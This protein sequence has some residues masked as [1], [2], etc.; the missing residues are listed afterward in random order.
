MISKWWSSAR[1]GGWLAS[2][3]RQSDLRLWDVGTRRQAASWPDQAGPA[4]VPGG[5]SL[6]TARHRQ[7]LRWPVRSLGPGGADGIGIGPA[8]TVPGPV[9]PHV[10]EPVAP[11]EEGI[12]AW[13]WR[14]PRDL[15][16]TNFDRSVVGLY[17][18]AEVTREKW[19]AKMNRA[20][21][22]A[23]SPDGHWVAAGSFEGG[24]GVQIREADSGRLEKELLT[25]DA[26]VAFSPNSRWLYTATGRLAPRGP[27][28]RAW[29]VGTWEAAHGLALDRS[30]SAPTGLAASPDGRALAV[31]ISQDAVRLLDAASFAEI[32]TLSAPE[33]GLIGSIRFSPDSAMLAFWASHLVHLWDL[34]RL[35]KEL[36]EVGLDWDALPYPDAPE[37]APRPRRVEVDLGGP[38]SASV[39][40]SP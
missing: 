6:L 13:C 15:F 3:Q 2:A 10:P 12:A 22:A 34:R 9:P 25:A 21:F 40:S 17:E 28:V 32:G 19:T 39:Q 14:G 11:S 27:E 24:N 38:G 7:L 23:A 5:E 16:V 37:V 31:S 35:R 4:W 29:R 36:A 26:E 30:S 20:A 1:T 8:R 33:T 18:M